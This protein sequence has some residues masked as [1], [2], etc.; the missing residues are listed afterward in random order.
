MR[1]GIENNNNKKERK[2]LPFFFFHNLEAPIPRKRCISKKLW[3]RSNGSKIEGN[4]PFSPPNVTT[5]AC[6]IPPFVILFSGLPK[7]SSV[8]VARQRTKTLFQ[9]PLE[10]RV[11]PGLVKWVG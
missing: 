4:Y 6:V 11:P 7:T 10:P 1:I 9:L 2:P 3:K 5:S 8:V